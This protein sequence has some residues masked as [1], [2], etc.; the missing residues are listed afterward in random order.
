MGAADPTKPDFQLA[1]GCLVD[2]LVGQVMAH[3]CGLG[4]LVDPAHVKTT[5]HNI[6]KYNLRGD[7]H[8][9]FNNMRAF[10]LDD[11]AALLMASYPKGRPLN[12]F[13]YFAEAMTG[14]E[15]TAAA[16]M[17]FE[18]AEDP[19]LFENGLR[20]ISLVRERYDGSRRNPF[21]EAECGH[22]YARAMASWAAILAFTGFH[23]SG[24]DHALTL[25]GREGR[26]VWSNGYSWG[27]YEM[28]TA[29]QDASRACRIA[30]TDGTLLLSRVSVR[31]FGTV[32]FDPPRRISAGEQIEARV[33]RG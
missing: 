18:G 4:Y 12:P 22:H 5:L 14:F 26:F 31:D 20:V 2:Q 25:G 10:A 1:N 32:M 9:H 6:L 30:V 13:P 8:G 7:L 19:R 3:V 28:S 29:D 23:Y 21:D 24:V 17:L 11:E 15:Y 27:A 33:R 16:G